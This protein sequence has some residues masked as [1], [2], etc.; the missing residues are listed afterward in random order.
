MVASKIDPIPVVVATVDGTLT[1]SQRI[2]N[3]RAKSSLENTVF[4]WTGPGGYTSSDSVAPV[5]V[6]GTYVLVGTS[7]QGCKSSPD[8]LLVVEEK[9][10]PALSTPEIAFC[11]P[12]SSTNLPAL[13][14][15]QEWFVGFPNPTAVSIDTVSNTANGLTVNGIY[16]IKLREGICIS[17]DS[18]KITRSPALVLRDSAATF[19]Q[20]TPVNL[21]DYILGYAALVNPVWHKGSASG[22]AIAT[23]NGVQ[24]TAS[25]KY[26]L[27]AQNQGGCADTATVTF[28]VP[29]MP[30]GLLSLTEPI[31]DNGT[32][33]PNGKITLSGFSV[34]MRYDLVQNATYNGTA[35]F[36]T[37]TAVPQDGIVASNLANP[38]GNTP[39]A[40]RIFN[41][42][43]CFQD[44]FVTLKPVDCACPIV[45]V[46]VTMRIMKK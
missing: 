41:E 34:A 27:I 15:G 28:T 37:A 29:V 14:K 31:C 8:T 36:A 43:G 39:Y 17:E 38:A 7:V 33:L 30:I 23:V 22:T 9:F 20:T 42:Q 4:S 1:C 25:E 24:I 10:P 40:C 26:V 6:P 5:S 19:C 46:P 35:T 13:K 16:Y 2:V 12:I 45:C 18:L 3:L 44:L 11:E 32:V 21:P